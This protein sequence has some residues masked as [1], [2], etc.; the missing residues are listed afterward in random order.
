[1]SAI[2]AGTE[3]D[4]PQP[5]RP[6]HRPWSFLIY[7][8]AD[9]DLDPEGQKDLDDI[10]TAGAS[11]RTH[12]G[13]EI[14][15]RQ[16]DFGSVRYEISE[17]DFTNT[18]YRR[19]IER[20][21]EQGTGDPRTLRNFVSWALRRC[22]A[23]ERVLIVWGHG[24]GRN[25]APDESAYGGALDMRELEDALQ[26]A[27]IGAAP[28]DPPPW[29]GQERTKKLA[30]LGFDACC[31]SMLE[32]V[33]EFGDR[34][35]YVVAS[36]ELV[37]ADGWPYGTLLTRAKAMLERE[38]PARA[39]AEA[40]VNGYVESYHRRNT[41]Q[42]TMAAIDVAAAATVRDAL[43]RLGYALAARMPDEQ[44]A[45]RRVRTYA[46]SHFL[47]DFVDLVHMAEL[48]REEF[49][50]AA[51]RR[52]AEETVAAA[53]QAVV[54]SQADL[55]RGRPDRVQNSSGLSVWFPAQRRAYLTWRTPYL[56]LRCNRPAYDAKAGWIA[57]LDAFH[58]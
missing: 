12:L 10:A 8:A 43:H 18:G 20:L 58:G 42:V 55:D 21:P 38:T 57:C 5:G 41:K 23:D 36:Q 32:N 46:R 54:R 35:E 24:M 44:A 28:D 25:V 37:P 52:A 11:L 45:L 14:D 7:I 49:A 47:I 6:P 1:M 33:I 19:V 26:Q 9:N 39:L 51:V 53:R 22:T 27:G 3:P 17:P 15:D 34:A 40:I 13:I 29:S 56:G 16:R 30:V 48:A 31:M 50:D 4:V 2:A